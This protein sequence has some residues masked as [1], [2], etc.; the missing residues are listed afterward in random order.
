MKY[1]YSCSNFIL[2]IISYEHSLGTI[3]NPLILVLSDIY[4]LYIDK[5][6]EEFQKVKQIEYFQECLF[7]VVYSKDFGW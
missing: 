3:A 6:D 1:E 2:F 7:V 4:S 5:M